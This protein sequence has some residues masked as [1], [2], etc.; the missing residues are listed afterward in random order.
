MDRD[1]KFNRFGAFLLRDGSAR[2][3]RVVDTG[4]GIEPQCLPFVF[5]R[6][7]Q[8]EGGTRRQFPGLGRCALRTPGLSS[9]TRSTRVSKPPKGLSAV[10][11]RLVA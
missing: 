6:F 2:V 4:I 11:G 5:E 3:I 9:Q 1:Q 10:R 8:A 7:W